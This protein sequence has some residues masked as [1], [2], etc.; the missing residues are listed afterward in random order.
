MS[1]PAPP[2]A[3]STLFA[4]LPVHHAGQPRAPPPRGSQVDEDGARYCGSRW[5][6]RVIFAHVRDPFGPSR[7]SLCHL[8]IMLPA[9]PE[10]KNALTLRLAS[11]PSISPLR[12]ETAAWTPDWHRVRTL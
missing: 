2:S 10:T 4:V 5:P 1:S 11:Q 9:W 7:P 3:S 8:A 6:L 12:S